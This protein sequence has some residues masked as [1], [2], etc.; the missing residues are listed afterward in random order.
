MYV[1]AR[2][3]KPNPQQVRSG[4]GAGGRHG[5]WAVPSCLAERAKWRTWCEYR[6]HTHFRVRLQVRYT[7]TVQ[8]VEEHRKQG[9]EW[10]PESNIRQSTRLIEDLSEIPEPGTKVVQFTTVF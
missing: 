5:S 4:R 1:F 3:L 9:D 2:K 10:Q 7:D 8:E 6:F